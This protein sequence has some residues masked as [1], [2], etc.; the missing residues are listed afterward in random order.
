MLHTDFRIRP[1]SVPATS[2][3]LKLFQFELP[4]EIGGR[5]GMLGM[6][7][8]NLCCRENHQSGFA[9]PVAQVLACSFLPLPCLF[10]Y[11]RESKLALP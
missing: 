8:E 11:L 7:N 6:K 2:G 3:S 9:C 1:R 4:Q 5:K 10:G